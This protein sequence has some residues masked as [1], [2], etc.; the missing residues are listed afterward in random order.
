[1]EGANSLIYMLKFPYFC[2]VGNGETYSI[3][4]VHIRVGARTG[5]H[6]RTTII[7]NYRISKR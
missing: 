2:F 1:M 3:V 4:N 6:N 7:H 5:L